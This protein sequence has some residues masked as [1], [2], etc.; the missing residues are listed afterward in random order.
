MD[1]CFFISLRVLWKKIVFFIFFLIVT[2]PNFA[3]IK[4][5]PFFNGWQDKSGKEVSGKH[6]IRTFW[7]ADNFHFQKNIITKENE[8]L[9]L[10]VHASSFRLKLNEQRILPQE[11][12][13]MEF[14][15]LMKQ[16]NN[17]IRLYRRKGMPFEKIPPAI[18]LCNY[19]GYLA[20]KNREIVVSTH[21]LEKGEVILKEPFSVYFLPKQEVQF[22]QQDPMN[23]FLN[24]PAS[25][26]E[27]LLP[28]PF[29]YDIPIRNDTALYYA[30]IRFS[31]P[32]EMPL[33]LSLSQ[34]E[35]VQVYFN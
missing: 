22:L 28:I 31:N 26:N 9:Y 13:N 7:Q 14:L 19:A 3:N 2:F 33:A 24:L 23:F 35:N 12:K 34:E 11:E 30:K 20:L 8:K 1:T 18:Y 4:I 15:F 29:A 16:G 5:I 25:K 21:K 6:F 17:H 32:V 10:F 27:W